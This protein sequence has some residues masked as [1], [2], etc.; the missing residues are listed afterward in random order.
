[1]NPPVDNELL[2]EQKEHLRFKQVGRKKDFLY[3]E[4]ID[5]RSTN[6]L[7][8]LELHTRVFDA[9]EQKKIVECVYN[10][11]RMGQKGQLRGVYSQFC[12][13]LCFIII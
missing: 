2:E 7:K 9:E 11:Q 5:G 1:M 13:S 3:L 10:L 8:G 4:R 12:I 6:V